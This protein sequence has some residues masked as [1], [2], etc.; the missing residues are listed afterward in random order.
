MCSALDSTINSA[1]AQANQAIRNEAERIQREQ[2][3]RQRREQPGIDIP[4][5]VT[6][7][8]DGGRCIDINRVTVDG[9]TEERSRTVSQMSKALKNQCIDPPH[10]IRTPTLSDLLLFE[11]RGTDVIELYRANRGLV[12]LSQAAMADPCID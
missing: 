5:P 6:L 1:Q 2:E 12:G 7:A 4:T 11:R 10:D 3:L 8:D 9:V